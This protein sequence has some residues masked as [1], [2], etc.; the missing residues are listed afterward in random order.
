MP[1]TDGHFGTI[2]INNVWI[3]VNCFNALFLSSKKLS[4]ECLW[5]L[6]INSIVIMGLN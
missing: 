3:H 2:G 4:V 1:E 6:F 5:L